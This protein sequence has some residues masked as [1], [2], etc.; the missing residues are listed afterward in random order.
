MQSRQS[1]YVI[2]SILRY[3]GWNHSTPSHFT[4]LG[5]AFSQGRRLSTSWKKRLP[6]ELA[7]ASPR[8]LHN[9]APSILK[10]DERDT[11]TH[12]ALSSDSRASRPPTRRNLPPLHSKKDDQNSNEEYFKSVFASVTENVGT[13][14]PINWDDYVNPDDRFRLS[15]E[16]FERKLAKKTDSQ[17]G[18]IQTT[19]VPPS[20]LKPTKSVQPLSIVGERS[21]PRADSMVEPE[22]V[23]TLSELSAEIDNIDWERLEKSDPEHRPLEPVEETDLEVIEVKPAKQPF[24]YNLASYANESDNIKKLID[25]DIEVWRFDRDKEISQL[26][27][28][29][30]WEVKVEP[31]IDWLKSFGLEK[32]DLKS[33]FEKFPRIVLEPIPNLQEK[34]DYFK[35]KKFDQVL[36]K[37]ILRDCPVIF[38]MPVRRIDKQLGEM[39]HR[40]GLVGQEVRNVMADYPK[41]I[42]FPLTSTWNIN[43]ICLINEMGFTKGE[44]KK[45]L[46]ANPRIMVKLS[47]LVIS[48]RFD[49]LHNVC[50]FPHTQIAAFPTIFTVNKQKVRER[51]LFLKA[52]K[53]NQYDPTLPNYISPEAVCTV[54]DAQFCTECAKE[55][56]WT[57][58]EFCKTL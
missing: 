3:S 34:I 9:E 31:W 43:R 4:Q 32:N 21:I 18:T 15:E 41:F 33:T 14:P 19:F 26:F 53:R 58:D 38:S 17:F 2:L 51:H 49:Y 56:V 55:S 50:G 47:K 44:V 54:T 8:S 45:M 52:L 42:T 16:D 1:R 48:D 13:K 37:K 11:S 39:Q 6:K 57:F 22:L 24:S 30:D 7:L 10:E 25:M 5:S 27:L 36:L 28:N 29:A 46:L 35:S 12:D 40:F 20:T 23:Q